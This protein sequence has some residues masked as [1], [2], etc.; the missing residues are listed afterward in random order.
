MDLQTDFTNLEGLFSSLDP[1]TLGT[2]SAVDALTS[3][4][5]DSTPLATGLSD[6][7]T[8]FLTQLPGLF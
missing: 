8:D 1:A 7:A 6:V 2:A 3:G 5:A 4:V